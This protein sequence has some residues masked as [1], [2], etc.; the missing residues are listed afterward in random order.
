MSQHDELLDSGAPYGQEIDSGIL[1][2]RF[3]FAEE[4]PNAPETPCQENL[5]LP[6]PA[7]SNPTNIQPSSS[8]ITSS[9]TNSGRDLYKKHHLLR[10][11]DVDILCDQQHRPGGLVAGFIGHR[12]LS[13]LVG[14]SGLGKSPLAYQLAICVAAGIPFLGMATESGRVVYAD[15]ENALEEGRELRNNMLQFLKLP[16]APNDFMVWTPECGDSLEIEGICQEVEP[17]LFIIDSLRAHNPHFEHKDNAGKEMSNLR[18]AAYK[19]GTAILLVHHIRKPGQE[20]APTLEDDKTPVMIWLNQAAG[21]RSIANQ[22]DTR[23]ATDLSP[24]VPDA[25]MLIRW[26]RRMRGEGGPVYIERVLNDQGDPIGYQPLI[27]PSLLGNS[28]Q[29]EAFNRLPERFSFKE[30]KGIYGRADDPTRKWLLKCIAAGLVHQA[31]KGVYQR[32]SAAP[33]S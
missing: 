13:I 12:S 31:T 25:A 22:S 21:H 24:R 26:Y 5:D 4:I 14:D 18:S 8:D 16:K 6:A 27:G 1:G 19:H 3:I 11:R 28:E 9:G 23:I 17:S 2:E 15:Y 29:E 33:A 7:E 10:P 32:V 20:G 30:A